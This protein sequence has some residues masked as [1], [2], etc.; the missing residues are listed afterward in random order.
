M[1]LMAI[2]HVRVYAGVPAGG[3]EPAIF[4]TRWVTHFCAPGFAFFA[5]TAAFLYGV[6]INNKKDLARYLFTRGLLLVVLE[7][8]LIRFGWTFNLNF[9]GFVLAGVIW[10]LG[11]CMILL[12]LL[13]RFEAKAVGIVGLAIIFFQQLFAYVSPMLPEPLSNYWEF[14]Y[15]SGA[16]GP[17]WIA[18]LYVIV[19][20]V[21]VMAAGYG[22]GKILLMEE[23]R[24]RKY[25]Y[26]IGLSAIA[27]FIVV[28]SIFILT[29][30]PVENSPPFL[31]RLL[32]QRKYP[33]SQLYL[34]MTLGP[35]IALIPLAEKARGAFADFLRVFGRVPFFYY[36]AHIPL[37]HVSALIVNSFLFGSPHQEWYGTAP[38]ANVPPENMWN[39]GVL[40]LVFAID[41]AL[42][43]VAS[44][45]YMGYKSSHPEKQ[46]LKYV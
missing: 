10:M 44:K 33:A 30:E 13:V 19:P 3:P 8:T 4:F 34:M 42:L 28:G 16:D 12:G 41:V 14:I 36:L 17:S 7:F 27:A 18:I 21:G 1:V 15:S 35:L 29:S 32:N 46:W 43:Y 20:W 39:L 25:C 11:V 26:I 5:G 31:L 9:S 6:K 2:D 23:K 45:W 38:F 37:I 24:M 40:Y 22:F